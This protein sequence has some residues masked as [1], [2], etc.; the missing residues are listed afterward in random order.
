MDTS[1]RPEVVQALLDEQAALRRVATLV[2]AAGETASVFSTVT[3]EVGRLLG[4]HTANMVRFRHTGTAEVIG[5]WNEPGAP[6]MPVGAVVGLEGETLVPK[7]CRSGR[8]ERVDD[9]CGLD[10]ALAQRLRELG[11]RSGVGAPIIFDGELWGAVVVSSARTRTF[12]AGDEIGRAS[13]RER[14]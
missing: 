1:D 3:E 7:I 10:D 6:R 13:C 8:P 12:A 14:V 11:I 9:Y 2:A 5:G 4:A